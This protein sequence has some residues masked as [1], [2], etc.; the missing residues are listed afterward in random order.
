MNQNKQDFDEF[1]NN[2]LVVDSLFPTFLRPVGYSKEMESRADELM[3][4]NIDLDEILEEM[5]D[6]FEEELYSG[7]SVFWDW[8]DQS[9]VDTIVTTVGDVEAVSASQAYRSA[10]T[11]IAGWNKR[12]D[13]FSEIVKITSAE[14]IQEAREKN[15]NGVILGL[16]NATSMNH[17]LGK[18]DVLY[19]LGVRVVQLTYN[20]RNSIGDGCTERTNAGLSEFGIKVIREMNEMGILIDLSHCGEQTTKEAIKL[21]DGPVAFT[22]AFCRSVHDHDRGKSDSEI[23]L[24]A[25]NDGYMGIL[26]LPDFI[27]DSKPTL[28]TY[29]DHIEHAVSIMGVDRVGIG[30]DYGTGAYTKEMQKCKRAQ[31]RREM[32]ENGMSWDGWKIHHWHEEMPS[33]EGY[34]DWRDFPNLTRKLLERGFTKAQSRKI[35]GQNFVRVFQDAVG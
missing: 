15:R 2:T 33:I 8:W 13:S 10:I 34:N 19:N 1:H 3:R 4:K 24:L 30:T 35:L 7:N 27:S 17:D 6:L 14:G 22:H 25:E 5:S 9:G 18:L 31:K 32:Q 11:Q 21:S 20:L 28:D 23:R 16:Q 26:I 12:F 29:V